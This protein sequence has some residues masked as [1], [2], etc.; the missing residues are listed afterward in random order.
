[1]LNKALLRN[2]FL[3]ICLLM[4]GLLWSCT[5]GK[6]HFLRSWDVSNTFESFTVVPGLT[7]YYN[8]LENRPD[9][10]V[11]ISKNY[12]LDSPHW[13]EVNLNEKELRHMIEEILNTVGVVPDKLTPQGAEILNDRGETIGLWYSAWKLPLVNFLPG[14]KIYMSQ[15]QYEVPAPNQDPI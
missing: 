9:A 15:P 4:A 7:Y 8:G 10:I 6:V 2:T 11:A 1:M 13:H 5:A 14:N 3:C 12:E